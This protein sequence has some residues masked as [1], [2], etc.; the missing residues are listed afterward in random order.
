MQTDQ[1]K[2]TEKILKVLA[3]KRRLAIIAYIK[4]KKEAPV[5]EIS[6]AIG[7]SFKSTSRH[8][9]LLAA[10]DILEREQR[11]LEMFYSL[12]ADLRPLARIIIDRL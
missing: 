3:N 2:E 10:A 8:L 7:L 6:R 5:W 11:S 1:F 9:A 4:H 12:A